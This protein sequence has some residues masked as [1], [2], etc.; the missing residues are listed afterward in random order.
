M[1]NVK[2]VEY[3]PSNYTLYHNSNYLNKEIHH[4]SASNYSLFRI[5]SLYKFKLDNSL[6]PFELVELQI[7]SV[8]INHAF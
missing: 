1:V 8:R 5:K 3:G 7:N 2:D 6:I 4:I